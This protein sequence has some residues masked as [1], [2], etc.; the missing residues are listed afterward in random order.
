[1]KISYEGHDTDFDETFMPVTAEEWR[2]IKRKLGL[3]VR[4]VLAGMMDV[5]ADAATAVRWLVLRAAGQQNLVL[6]P[7][8]EFSVMEF[9][10]AWREAEE[11]EPEPEPDPTPAGSPPATPTPESNG[12]TTLT[13]ASSSP[14]ISSPSPGTA[15]S[16]SGKPDS[17]PSQDSS[18]M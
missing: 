2:E 1:M 3:T 16:A 14:S 4:G 13:S 11:A 5:D 6:D 17:S 18:P 7:A 12:S 9:A 8:A 15:G 10:A